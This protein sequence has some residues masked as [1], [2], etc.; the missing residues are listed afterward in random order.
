M[1]SSTSSSTSSTPS[2]STPSSP[3]THDD[4]HAPARP[5]GGAPRRGPEVVPAH[6]LVRPW[7]DPVV[8]QV[9]HDPRSAYV[10]QFWLATLGPSTT[11]LLRRLV[12]GLDEAPDGF[13]LDLA[14]TARAL[15]LGTRAGRNSPFLRA[16]ERSRQ[17]SLTRE[18]GDGILAVRRRLPPLS[19]HQVARLPLPLQQAH[20]QWLLGALA[21]PS[22]EDQRRRARRLA[23][24]LFELG[25]DR[26]SA[27][28]QLHRWRF[29]PAVA[30]DAVN[31]GWD[32][33]RVAAK[34]A[35]RQHEAWA[36]RDCGPG[37]G[38]AA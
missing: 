36:E 12:S 19:R 23:L 22:V 8:D 25:E 34:A 18:T 28:H 27:E 13:E 4:H 9:G 32:R 38:D 26:E 37:Q 29:H 35:A 6:L 1:T 3:S 5:S 21:R 7:V 15:G 11:W 20:E 16:L 2:Y 33:H 17:F 24:S 31:W 14:T 30:H 10:E